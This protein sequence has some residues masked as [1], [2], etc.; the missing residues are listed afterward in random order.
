VVA[1]MAV[2]DDGVATRRRSAGTSRRRTGAGWLDRRSPHGSRL[3]AQERETTTK[4][5]DPGGGETTINA[6]RTPIEP[7]SGPHSTRRAMVGPSSR[8]EARWVEHRIA[9]V[10][11]AERAGFRGKQGRICRSQ[12]RHRRQPGP[13]LEPLAEHAGRDCRCARLPRAPRARAWARERG[14]GT[15]MRLLGRI[16][17]PGLDPRGD[18]PRIGPGRDEV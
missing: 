8:E 3:P 17:N 7:R 6:A 13:G 15:R 5:P 12:G 9:A 14:D 4:T 1:L 10:H 2:R 16:E 11:R 18:P